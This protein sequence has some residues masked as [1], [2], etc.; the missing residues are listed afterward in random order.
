MFSGGVRVGK[1]AADLAI[2][3]R[4]RKPER[5]GKAQQTTVFQTPETL[6]CRL[7]LAA[8]DQ[9]HAARPLLRALTAFASA[10]CDSDPAFVFA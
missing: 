8:Q 2:F 3:R 5:P 10:I 9:Q 4:P 6:K 7:G 1:E